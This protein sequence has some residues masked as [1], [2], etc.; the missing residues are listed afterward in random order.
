MISNLD[1]AQEP[2]HSTV[3][4]CALAEHAK[5]RHGK[6]TLSGIQKIEMATIFG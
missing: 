4:P 6:G 2:W 3:N 5:R 1:S